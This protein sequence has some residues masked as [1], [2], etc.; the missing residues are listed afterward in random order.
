MKI[1]QLVQKMMG[2]ADRPKHRQDGD[3]IGLFPFL[4]SRLKSIVICKVF[5][6]DQTKYIGLCVFFDFSC[7]FISL[8]N[9]DFIAVGLV[10]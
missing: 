1:Y 7:V 9:Q 10:Y 4:E 5:W 3:L 8:Y 2:G 6:L